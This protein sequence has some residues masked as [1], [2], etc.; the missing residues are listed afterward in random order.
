LAG[1]PDF[2]NPKNNYYV[3]RIGKVPDID[4]EKYRLEITGLAWKPLSFTLTELPFTGKRG[5][6]RHRFAEGR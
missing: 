2:I 3:T 5:S 4:P 1:F 6:G